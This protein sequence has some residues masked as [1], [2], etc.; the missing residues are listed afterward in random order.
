MQS[1]AV[2][3]F[4]TIGSR[5]NLFTEVHSANINAADAATGQVA[6]LECKNPSGDI[7]LAVEVKDRQLTL[8]QTQEK[9]PAIRAKGIS[10]FVFLVQGGI[11][12]DDVNNVEE[13]ARKEF[14]SGQNIYV[15]DFVQFFD[16]CLVL[17]GEQGRHAFLRAV[18]DALD[19]NRAD[20]SH[21]RAWRE[22]LNTL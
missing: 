21:R 13:I 15:S 2:A 17:F 14:A 10:E 1:V 12:P 18:G 5:F 20:I 8:V 6:D 11:S 4:R 22:G 3:L 16:T 9:V 7:V 19:E